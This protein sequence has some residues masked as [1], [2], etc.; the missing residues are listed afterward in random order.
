MSATV[1][2]VRQTQIDISMLL[3]E[4]RQL[5]ASGDLV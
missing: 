1:P 3:A 2:F 4:K 5:Q